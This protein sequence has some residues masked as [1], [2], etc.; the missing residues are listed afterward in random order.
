MKK[1][2][3]EFKTFAMKGNVLDMA[4]G[5]MIGGAFTSIVNS[6]VSDVFTPII[7]MITGGIDFS[8]LTLGIGNAQ[9]RI[10]NFINAVITFLLVAFSVFCLIKMISKLRRKEEAKPTMKPSDEVILLT[11]IR[12][13]LKEKQ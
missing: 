10:G 1:F 7:G 8:N 2:I 5:I 3:Q 12:D 4:V 11:E 9:I 6:L 13:I